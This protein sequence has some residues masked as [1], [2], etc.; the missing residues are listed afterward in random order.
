MKS[1]YAFY[2]THDSFFLLL[3]LAALIIYSVISI[4]LDTGLLI[5]LSLLTLCAIGKLWNVRSEKKIFKHLC[6]QVKL[7]AEGE[8]DYRI[9]GIKA[10][11]DYA[12]FISDMNK[13]FDK[14][15]I[16]LK[17]SSKVFMSTTFNRDWRR[18]FLDDMPGNY[19][20]FLDKVDLFAEKICAG[21]QRQR[22]D[23]LDSKLSVMRATGLLKLMQSNKSDMS[24]VTGELK[25]TESDTQGFVTKSSDGS[26]KAKQIV[27]TT[28]S[29][30]DILGGMKDSSSKLGQ[31][32]VDINSMLESIESLADQT[33]LL[34]LN[35][36]IESARAGEHG[37][38]FAVVADEVRNLAAST[39]DITSN[40]SNVVKSIVNSSEQVIGDT[41]KISVA[42]QKFETIAQ[43]FSENFN[44]FSNVSQ[45]IYARIGQS[46][47]MNELNLLKQEMVIYLQDGY[48]VLDVGLESDTA[49][50]LAKPLEEMQFTIWYNGDGERDYG[51]LPSFPKL[52]DPYT[53][54]YYCYQQVLI[55]IAKE[56]WSI[57]ED[58]LQEILNLYLQVEQYSSCFVE[59]V[60]QMAL[61]KS[62][63]E[64]YEHH[65]SL[66]QSAA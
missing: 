6:K 3:V 30:I 8:L 13:A 54:I 9:T 41:E 65:A 25:Y 27:Q 12:D 34:A 43:D 37:R 2:K 45:K 4:G 59:L 28:T 42:T 63:Q 52:L 26:S 22:R 15:E 18:V 17:E 55:L 10:D 60:D 20:G 7:M 11:A 51:N 64:G 35:A 61:E 33:N 47:M 38:G 14:I 5:L 19:G 24:F 1:I 46:R 16:T 31:E 39:K 49:R 29:L 56:D 44:S 23:T 50:N 32:I 57:D 40:I 66:G 48:Q 58:Q 36:A 62:Q 21:I 53:S